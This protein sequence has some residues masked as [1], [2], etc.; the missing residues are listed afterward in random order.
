[1]DVWMEA[2]PSPAL[3]TGV[4]LRTRRTEQRLAATFMLR[5]TNEINKRVVIYHVNLST[6][7]LFIKH[8]SVIMSSITR[9]NVDNVHLICLKL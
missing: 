5:E 1:M 6:I 4:N 9:I 8:N 2:D 7:K 3:I